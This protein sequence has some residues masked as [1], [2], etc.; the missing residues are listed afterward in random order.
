MYL[1]QLVIWPQDPPL[2]VSQLFGSFS[3]HR[4]ENVELILILWVRL[5]L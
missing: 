3:E 1:K 4:Q 2:R 5:R